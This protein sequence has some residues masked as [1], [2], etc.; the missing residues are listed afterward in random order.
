MTLDVVF[1]DTLAFA[2]GIEHL[3]EVLLLV[4]H[5]VAHLA[6]VVGKVFLQY[7]RRL[8]A[9]RIGYV[10]QMALHVRQTLLDVVAVGGLQVFGDHTAVDARHLLVVGRIVVKR[11]D[12]AHREE[13]VF[14]HAVVAA[15]FFHAPLAEA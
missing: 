12:V 5:V 15:H 8:L 1:A 14:V 3:V 11:V 9:C 2:H 6:A 13:E 10:V 4:A 7:R